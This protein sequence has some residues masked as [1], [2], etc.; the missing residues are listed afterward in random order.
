MLL[1]IN[2]DGARLCNDARWRNTACFGNVR[3]CVKTYK[4]TGRAL[5]RALRIGG[6]VVRVPERMT[7]DAAGTVI[8]TLP[9]E[10]KPGF[11]T[12]RHHALLDFRVNPIDE[13]YGEVDHGPCETGAYS[14]AAG[15]HD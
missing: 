6:I 5:R 13:D 11:V 10:G 2:S 1:I 15:Y 7:V 9:C 3:G 12:Y 8:E 14:H 4:T